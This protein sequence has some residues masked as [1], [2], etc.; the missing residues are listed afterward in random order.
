VKRLLPVFALL[1][2]GFLAGCAGEGPTSQELGDQ[3][4]RGVR[5]EG[6]LSPDIDRSSDPYVKPREGRENRPEASG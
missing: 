4:G 6:Q 3:L 5:G 2:S 1:L